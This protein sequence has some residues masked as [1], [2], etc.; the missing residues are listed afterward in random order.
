L[1]DVFQEENGIYRFDRATKLDTTRIK[2]IQTRPA[3]YENSSHDGQ[4]SE[5]GC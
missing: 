5:L 3:A 4:G 2:K 1:T